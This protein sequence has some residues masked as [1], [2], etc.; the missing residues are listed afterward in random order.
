MPLHFLHCSFAQTQIENGTFEVWENEDNDNEEPTQWSP[1]KTSDDNN[2]LID[3]A[4]QSPKVI[5]KETSNPHG[6]S[7]CLKL[8]VASYNALAG[9]SPNAIAT[10]GRVFASTTVTDT[11][12]YTDSDAQ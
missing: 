3:L 9:L 2:W 4:N 11:Y 10:N 5:W 7:A 8:K 1:L 6:G 12:V